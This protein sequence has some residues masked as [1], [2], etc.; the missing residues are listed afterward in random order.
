GAGF[1]FFGVQGVAFNA[2]DGGVFAKSDGFGAEVVE[3]GGVDVLDVGGEFG[4]ASG[5]RGALFA[6]GFGLVAQRA[7]AVIELGHGGA[8][9]GCFSGEAGSFG[10]RGSA[11]LGEFGV[12][13]GERCGLFFAA[14]FFCGGGFELRLGRLVTLVLA[15]VAA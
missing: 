1:F 9:F 8:E 13:D 15:V 11:K 3:A 2:G 14:E 6:K 5:E 12:L 10:N 4:G 7:E